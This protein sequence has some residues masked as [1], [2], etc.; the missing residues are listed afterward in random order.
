M[1]YSLALSLPGTPVLF[2]GEEIGMAENLGIEGRLAVRSP[3]QWSAEP[4]GG[5]SEVSDPALLCRPLVSADGFAPSHV[6]VAAQRRGR[7]SLLNWFERLIRRRHETPALGWGRFALLPTAEAPVFAH[8]TDWDDDTFVAAHNLGDAAV[9]TSF[10]LED[11]ED[12]EALVDLF[13][14]GELSLSAGRVELE[15]EPFGARWFHVRR[16]GR[17]VGL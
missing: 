4:N 12:A 9:N 5:F 1:L 15:L 2:Y 10:V 16:R 11:A 13:G 6:S 3:M 17:R 14:P 8:R 7:D